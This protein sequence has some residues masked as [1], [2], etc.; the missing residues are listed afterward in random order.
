[1][2]FDFCKNERGTKRDARGG[3]ILKH[4]VPIL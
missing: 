2:R 1:L 4:E 3:D